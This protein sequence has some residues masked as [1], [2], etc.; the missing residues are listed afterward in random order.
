M[1]NHLL[2]WMLKQTPWGQLQLLDFGF[3]LVKLFITCIVCGQEGFFDCLHMNLVSFFYLVLMEDLSV[4]KASSS[5]GR[6]TGSLILF[7]ISP[8]ITG[9][10]ITDLGCGYQFWSSFAKILAN[11]LT[12]QW[13]SSEDWT[14]SPLSIQAF[15]WMVHLLQLRFPNRSDTFKEF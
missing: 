13:R 11:N 2:L 14:R 5:M 15:I 8:R 3:S 6:Y 7:A 4:V 1:G 12:N 9:V 10:I